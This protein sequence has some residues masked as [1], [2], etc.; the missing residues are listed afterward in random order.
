M[1]AFT[2]FDEVTREIFEKIEGL[3]NQFTP[4]DKFAVVTSDGYV[5]I[6]GR[7]FDAN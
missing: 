7:K 5:T 6:D 1:R 3:L 4:S 2:I